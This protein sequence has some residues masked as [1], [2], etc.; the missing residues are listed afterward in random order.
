MIVILIG[1]VIIREKHSEISI[2]TFVPIFLTLS[3][4]IPS[5]AFNSASLLPAL[6]LC[7]QRFG[8]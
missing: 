6:I 5:V 7:V 3:I 2:V 4:Q 1:T 8:Y